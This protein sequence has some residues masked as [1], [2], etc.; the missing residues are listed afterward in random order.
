MVLFGSNMNLENKLF[1]YSQSLFAKA[2]S[3]R[4][5]AS[6]FV[7][8]NR[9]IGSQNLLIVL[10]GFQP[11]YWDVLFSRLKECEHFFDESIDICIC[12][13]RGIEEIKKNR[14]ANKLRLICRENNWSY[15]YLYE[16]LLAQAQNT[17]I[18]LH[19]NAKWI[20]K[21]DEDII[22][23]ISYFG[24]LKKAYRIAV[25]TM[26][27]Y[28]GMLS[29]L[30]N[31]N[32]YGVVPFLK[33]LNLW[34]EFEEKFGKYYYGM[35]NGGINAGSG[36][37]HED[38]LMAL[39]IW[40]KS[41]PFD[42]VSQEIF[43]ANKGRIGICKNRLSIGAILFERSFWEEIN[44]FFVGKTG[45]MGLEEE[46]VNAFCISNNRGIYIDESLLA[47]HMG[48]GKQKKE[49]EQFYINNSKDFEVRK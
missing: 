3:K 15:L 6:K 22:L 8:D 17:A 12:V 11:I 4:L 25:D 24:E 38:P 1:K 23:P 35:K 44:Y 48:F 20:Y 46:Q 2:E 39:W 45:S 47:G 13:P 28:P 31:I 34:R 37:I 18:Q 32:A 14:N 42:K 29:P 9:S 43:L 16:D 7:F 26:P 36:K 41:I 27:Y 33:G 10:V 49:I 40:Q 19:P 5:F 30:L 21:I